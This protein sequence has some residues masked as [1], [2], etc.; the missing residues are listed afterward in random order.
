MHRW[1]IPFINLVLVFGSSARCLAADP[2]ADVYGTIC[3]ICHQLSGQG[4]A[5]TIP[6]LAGR[7]D[8]IAST[9]QGRQYLGTLVLY[10]MNGNIT[11]DGSMISGVMPPFLSLSDET[12]AATL[13]H[14]VRLGGQNKV[15]AFTAAEIRELR[16]TEPLSGSAVHALRDALKIDDHPP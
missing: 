3:S 10:G 2:A 9:T 11:V 16:R 15:K 8:R 7:V 13:N 14:V 5:G 12:L 4:L 6:R 1:G